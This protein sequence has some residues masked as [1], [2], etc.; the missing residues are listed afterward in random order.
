MSFEIKNKGKLGEQV[1]KAASRQLDRALSTL[2]RRSNSARSRDAAVHNA[3]KRLKEVRALLRLVREGLGEKPF[4]RENEALRDAARP[5]S[6]LRDAT[7]LLEALEALQEHYARTVN[8]DT[9][10]SARTGL[11]RRRTAIR[12]RVLIQGHALEKAAKG[13]KEVRS[14]ANDWDL[15]RGSWQT[16]Q[17]GL[18]R[19]YKK[20]HKAMTVS[21]GDTT[22][23]NLHEWR[24]RAK[25]IRYQLEL[26]EPLWPEVMKATAAQAKN[27]TELLG[28]D[29]DLAVLRGLLDRE[30]KETVPH[31]AAETLKGLI[32]SRRTELQHSAMALSE[33]LFAESPGQFV[34]RLRTYWKTA[35]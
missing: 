23:E 7:A 17:S 28:D 12:D 20:G 29:H 2:R 4:R 10:K 9:F 14:R 6:E 26:L 19:A 3:R 1:Q 11:R 32:D 22:D 33:K 16:L 24:K 35:A 31:E 18:Q 30:L 21:A 15:Q 27:L 13:V 25:D 34:D 8:K 5:L